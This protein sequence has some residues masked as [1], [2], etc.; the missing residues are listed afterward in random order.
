MPTTPL[1]TALRKLAPDTTPDGE[2]LTR[3]IQADDDDAFQSLVHRHGGMVRRLCQR[4][5]RNDA[6]TNDAVQT[7]FP[8]LFCKAPT[9]RDRNGLANWLCGVAH[10]LALKVYG[11]SNSAGS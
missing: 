5:L 7:T 2:L 1:T 9:I 4:I 6:D 8:I 11:L 10:N 3:C